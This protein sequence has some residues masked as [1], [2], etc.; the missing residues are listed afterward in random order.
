[1]QRTEGPWSRHPFRPSVQHREQ[2]ARRDHSS[3]ARDPAWRRHCLSRALIGPRASGD[4][5]RAGPFDGNDTGFARSRERRRVGGCRFPDRRSRERGNPA[6]CDS[7][8]YDPEGVTTSLTRKL[9]LRRWLRQGE[10]ALVVVLLQLV[11][12]CQHLYATRR[13]DFIQCDVAGRAGGYYKLATSRSAAL[14]CLAKGPGNGRKLFFDRL[15]QGLYR[16]VDLAQ[17]VKVLATAQQE[18]GKANEVILR[19]RGKPHLTAPGRH[20]L[21]SSSRRLAS[22]RF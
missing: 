15:S 9:S 3:N 16:G 17:L 11:A 22:M 21:V 8:R 10:L 13:L 12:H 4:R 20:G 14:S 2:R 19:R 6:A 7:R 1:M 18:I 5:C